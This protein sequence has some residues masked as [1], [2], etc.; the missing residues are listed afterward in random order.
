LFFT[1]EHGVGELKLQRGRIIDASFG[2][3]QGE[4]AFYALMRQERGRFEFQPGLDN[5]RLVRTV[6]APTTSLLMEGARQLDMYRRE[7]ASAPVAAEVG[8]MAAQEAATDTPDAALLRR[9]RLPTAEQRAD[10]RVVLA[11]P[12]ALGEIRFQNR[13]QLLERTMS[14]AAQS[15]I[16]GLLVA[17]QLPGVLQFAGMASP[18]GEADIAS[19][20]EWDQRV[21]MLS[22]QG[23]HGSAIDLLLLDCAFP[24]MVL[25][26]LRCGAAFVLYAPPQGDHL[27]LGHHSLDELVAMLG[28]LR[29]DVMVGLGNATIGACLEQV[30]TA[31]GIAPTRMVVHRPIEDAHTDLRE[32]LVG[33]LDLLGKTEE[34]AR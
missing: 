15:R 29:P 17:P 13:G 31:A 6:S 25:D 11:D 24:A 28:H 10:L 16:F 19:A 1:T 9:A 20:L 33:V 23:A 22:M 7:R 32:C 4:P 5:L 27:C 8:A 12:F 3:I 21:L 18:L 2:T 26:D 14:T 34:A 30:C